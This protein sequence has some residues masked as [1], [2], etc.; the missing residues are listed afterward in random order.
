MKKIMNSLV[1][2]IA[3]VALAGCSALGGNA[4]TGSGK[5]TNTTT[6]TT[7]KTN[8]ALAKSM[9][10]EWAIMEVGKTKISVDEDQPYVNFASDGRF[11]A[12]NGCNILNGAYTVQGSTVTF[13]QVLSTMRSCANAPFEGAINKI[14]A[15]GMSVQA[16]VSKIG[17]E[18]YLYLND[19][20]G[21]PL[22]TLCHHNMQFLNGEWLVTAING[23]RVDDEEANV[24]FDIAALKIHGNTGCNYFNGDILINPGEANS[25]SFSGMGVTRMACPKGD[26]ERTMLVAL[27]ETAKALRVN[28]NTVALADKNGKQVLTLTRAPQR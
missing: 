7:V 9:E 13:S 26:Q 8:T 2:A 17:N 4:K 28:D 18:S 23:Q 10:G 3:A 6:N 5:K 24:F 15:D 14:I 21:H 25:I 19:R 27:E 12:S 20:N 22:M 16:M 1:I 11:Y